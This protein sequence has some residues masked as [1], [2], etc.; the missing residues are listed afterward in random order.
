MSEAEKYA[1]IARESREK[2]ITDLADVAWLALKEAGLTIE[3]GSRAHEELCD[4]VR[5]ALV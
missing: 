4:A 1:R 2:Y 3:P 5:T